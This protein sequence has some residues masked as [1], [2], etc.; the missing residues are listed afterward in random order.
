MSVVAVDMRIL[1]QQPGAAPRVLQDFTV[2]SDSGHMPGA[3]ETMGV[4]A[5]A[6]SIGTSAALSG[7]A[8]VV[9]ETRRAGVEDE[10]AHAADMLADNVRKLLVEHGWI[11]GPAK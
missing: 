3:A 1:Y 7:G 4:G 6:G 2:S 11:A 5:A 10:A 8:H 9:G